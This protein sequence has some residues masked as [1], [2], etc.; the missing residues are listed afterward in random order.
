MGKENMVHINTGVPFNKNNISK[1][2]LKFVVTVD[3]MTNH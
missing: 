1:I 3:E 2:R